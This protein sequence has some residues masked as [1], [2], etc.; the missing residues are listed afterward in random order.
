MLCSRARSHDQ[1]RDA[2][3]HRVLPQMGHQFVAVHARHFEVGDDQM[4]ADWA[5]IS[6][7][8]SP[9]DASFTR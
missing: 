8:S 9:S 3:R 4:A 1:H 5:T 6:E 7:A 2:A